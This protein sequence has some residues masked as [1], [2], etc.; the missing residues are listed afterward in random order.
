MVLGNGEAVCGDAGFNSPSV[1][2]YSQMKD[3][4]LL[5][6]H[7]MLRIAYRHFHI[8]HARFKKYLFR[9]DSGVFFVFLF[10]FDR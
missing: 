4:L 8:A 7:Y 5:L 6:I 1:L 9:F 10:E 2:A 3:R